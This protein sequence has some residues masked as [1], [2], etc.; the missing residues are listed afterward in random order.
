MGGQL[1]GERQLEKQFQSAGLGEGAWGTRDHE[2]QSCP[3][4]AVTAD[5]TGHQTSQ[6]VLSFPTCEVGARRRQDPLSTPLL[7]S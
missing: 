1:E 3:R 6:P 2:T 7:S 5:E 4:R